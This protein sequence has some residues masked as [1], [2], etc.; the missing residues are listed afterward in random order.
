MGAA[1]VVLIAAVNGRV[2]YSM[3]TCV[4]EM[5]SHE[6]NWILS[7]SC[8]YCLSLVSNCTR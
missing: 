4:Y 3:R 2:L 6:I 8:C 1:D 7:M 5:Q